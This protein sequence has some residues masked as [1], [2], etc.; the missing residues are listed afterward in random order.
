M[1]DSIA[2]HPITLKRV[3]HRLPGMDEGRTER[4]LQYHQSDAGPLA[5]DVYHPHQTDGA[6]TPVVLFGLGVSRRRCGQ[7]DGLRVQGDGD[8]HLDGATRGQLRHG[9]RNLYHL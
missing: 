3:V 4:D 9:G 7:S 6:P 1:S 8:V 2:R 5:L